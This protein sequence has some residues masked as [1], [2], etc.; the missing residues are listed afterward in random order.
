MTLVLAGI[1]AA[2]FWGLRRLNITSDLARILPK[3]DQV[4]ADTLYVMGRHPIL[5]KVFV[6]LSLTGSKSDPDFLVEAAGRIERQLEASGLFVKV[7]LGPL[8]GTFAK[9]VSRVVDNLPGLFDRRTLLKRVLP[10]LTPVAIEARMAA[11][12]KLLRDLSG[13]GQ[14]ALI[15]KDPLG[16]RNIIL[17]KLAK[18]F[19]LGS[20]RLYKGRIMSGDRQHLLIVAEPKAAGTDTDV[21]RK[22]AALLDRIS[23][24]WKAAGRTTG[25]SLKI[26]PVGAYRSSLDN[27]TIIRRDAMRAVLLATIGIALL[28]LISFPRPLIGLLALVPAVFGAALALFVYSLIRDQISGLALGFG[29]ALISISVDHAVAYL[30]FLDRTTPTSSLEAATKVRAVGL[31]AVLTTIGAFLA[32]GLSGFTL[33]WEIGLFAALG[34]ACSF[35]I[36]HTVF[37]LL[38]FGISPAKRAAR[39]PIERFLSAVAR[40]KSLIPVVALS[41]F[42]LTMLV[43]A[44]PV[45]H[46]DLKAMNTVT[47]STQGA[48]KT[49]AKVW[50]KAFHQTYLFVEAQSRPE[51]GVKTDRLAGWLDRELTTVLWPTC[52]RPSWCCLDRCASNETLRP[53]RSSGRLAVEQN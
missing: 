43:L 36:V 1:V 53:G 26:I 37:P 14:T 52:I 38:L 25:R 49:M 9:L 32:M 42:G 13:V 20:G 18:T 45:F 40:Q 22:I 3:T 39:L 50:R 51:M 28:L 30:L 15:A 16:L 48:E 5:D 21:A 10:L 8:E 34:V 7:G 35:A 24:Q 12:L 11:N 2:F 33:L 23:A 29:G 44:K 19:A 17:A 6:D 41:V 46:I 47:E 31:Y 27:E 4:V